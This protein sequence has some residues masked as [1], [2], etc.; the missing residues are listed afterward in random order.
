VTLP[1]TQANHNQP[2]LHALIELAS[3]CK[4]VIVSNEP[5]I[6]IM[7]DMHKEI[8]REETLMSVLERLDIRASLYRARNNKFALKML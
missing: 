6:S 7:N 3:W 8:I 4:V 1:N 5:D 2:L